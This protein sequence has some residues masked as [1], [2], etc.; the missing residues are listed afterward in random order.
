VGANDYAI[1]VGVERYPSFGRTTMDPN[2]LQGP[3]ND[4]RAMFDWLTD[5]DGGALPAENVR[6][7]TSAAY[8]DPF[9]NSA[10]VAPKPRDIAS[11]FRWL[12]GIAQRNNSRIDGPGLTVGNRLYLY[13]SG[14]GYARKRQ[15]AAV[16]TANATRSRPWHVEATDWATWF[17]HAEYFRE[18]VVWMDCCMNPD[19]SIRTEPVGYREVAPLGSQ[20]MFSAFAARHPFQAVEAMQ[21]DGQY[22]GAFTWSL[23]KGLRSAVDDSGAITSHS[24]KGY[25]VNAMKTFMTDEQ[26]RHERVSKEPDFGSEDDIVFVKAPKPKFEVT[27]R[28]PATAVGRRFQIITGIPPRN[29]RSGVVPSREFTVPLANGLYVVTVPVAKLTGEFEVT[30]VGREISIL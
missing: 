22:H 20:P 8:P 10:A 23:L 15:E 5:P 21:A 9:P 26:R 28:V 1:V 2:D 11:A 18:Y 14:H 7:V 27:V 30:G 25:L 16:F 3:D 29:A 19:L 6:C 4:A 12:E 17:Y 24:L 13:M